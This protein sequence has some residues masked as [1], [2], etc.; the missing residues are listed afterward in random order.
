MEIKLSCSDVMVPGS[1]LTDKAEKLRQWGYDG[2]AVF[3]SYSEWNEEKLEE[4][5]HLKENTGII[6]CEFVFM[7]SVYG[8]LMSPDKQLKTKAIAMYKD[9]IG[10]C[11]KIGAITEMEFDYGIQDPLP[12][13]EPYKQMSNS[14]EQEF[15]EV[16]K[17]LG[18]EAA[19]S[20]AYILLEPINRYETKYLTRLQD[21][22]AILEKA[23][24]SNSGLLPDFFHMSIEEVDL[25]RSI[26]NAGSYI[27]HV[28]LGDNNRLLPG[29]GHTNW[30]ACFQALN[31]IN[32]K[33][34]MNLECGISGAPEIELPETA[35]FLKK[36]ASTI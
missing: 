18:E 23:Q 19:G 13:F 5:L 10:V 33:G 29:Y 24:L 26:R 27:K 25:P 1:S 7:D 21:C 11:K 2:I 35:S 34:F 22:K 16:L 6:P 28:H 4:L 32:F 30:Q 36:I 14:E 12:L 9:A 20:D 15:I 3:T 31:E 17:Q 8:H